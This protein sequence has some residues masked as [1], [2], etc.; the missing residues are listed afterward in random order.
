MVSLFYTIY[1]R[2]SRTVYGGMNKT[3]N[4]QFMINSILLALLTL[5]ER[6]VLKGCWTVSA[7]ESSCTTAMA[8]SARL[9]ASVGMYCKAWEA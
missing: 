6:A 5:C 9:Q 7:I 8:A 4:E 1:I 3:T 2:K